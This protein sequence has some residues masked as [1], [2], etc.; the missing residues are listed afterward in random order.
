[1]SD[2]P[3]RLLRETLRGRAATASTPDCL[4]PDTLARWADGALSAR[5]RA[6]AESHASSCAHCQALVAAMART[7]PCEPERRPWHAF[8]IRW[9][10]PLAVAAA[11]VLV[12]INLPMDRA[13]RASPD[14]S[15]P[16]TASADRVLEPKKAEGASAPTVP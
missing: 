4:D 7:A 12:W 13:P 3:A 16:L 5:E 9:I 8:N 2:V 15:A 11:A 10:V 14:A 1:M 6:A